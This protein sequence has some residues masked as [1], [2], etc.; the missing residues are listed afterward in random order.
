MRKSFSLLPILL[1]SLTAC[2]LSAEQEFHDEGT[3]KIFGRVT[4]FENQPIKG[5]S[6][7][8]KDAKFEDVATAK[9]DDEGRYIITAP[10][11]RY[12]ALVAVKQYMVKYLEYWAWNVPLDQD[13]E[14]NPRFHRME[15]YAI[16][17]WRPQGGYPSYQIYFRPMSL[18]MTMDGIKEA[19]GM[20]NFQKLPVI[21]IAP[22]LGIDDIKVV[23]DEQR[24]NILEVNRVRESAGE[25]Q[26]MFG[27]LIHV[28][29]PDKKPDKSYSVITITLTDPVTGDKGEGCLF[30][31]PPEYSF[32]RKME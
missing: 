9:S 25:K 19:G 7:F 22:D 30:V 5:A 13:L 31:F 1:F 29:L 27:Y 10:K 4:D 12:M 20:A 15:V 24:V 26:H 23:I 32:A 2:F 14:I 6:V 3:L 21:D 16:N 28:A 11:G 17:A 8:L 18:S